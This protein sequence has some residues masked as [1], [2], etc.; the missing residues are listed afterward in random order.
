LT[1]WPAP[2]RPY[3]NGVA[4]IVVRRQNTDDQ[5]F[6][7]TVT[8]GNGEG[9]VSI[10]SKFGVPMSIDKGGH[11]RPQ[12][13]RATPE[14]RAFLAQALADAVKVLH[15]EGVSAFLAFGCLLGAVRD[16]QLIGHDS[17]GDLVY[18]ARSSHPFDVIL[19]SMELER[20]FQDKGWLTRRMS[21]GDFKLTIPLPDGGYVGC[22]VFTAFFRGESFYVMPYVRA[23]ITRADLEPLSEITLEGV[24]IPAP[25]RPEVLLE[26]TY[27]PGW[28][29]PDPSFAYHP[30]RQTRRQLA[31]WM[32]GERRHRSY[33]DE[34]YAR[35][36]QDVSAG[37]SPFASWVGEREPE[38]GSLVDIGA[39]TGRDSLWFA[40]QGFDVLGLDYSSEG[41]AL[42]QRHAKR[43]NLPA[44]FERMNLY[45][46]RRVLTTSALL[47]RTQRTDIVYARFLVH[48]LEDAGR[49]HLWLVAR[50]L[51][52]GS[53]GR[54]YIETRT[55]ATNHVFGEHFRQFVQADVIA[56]ELGTYGFDIEH[57]EEGHG[58]AVHKDED[59]RVCRIVA[60]MR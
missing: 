27:G 12:F 32:R 45:D 41:V 56:D 55:E 31:G 35:R 20:S 34:F 38:V 46:V 22:D 2:L 8:L 16:G 6:A 5:L 23:A 18:V 37:P 49:K 17:D 47:A 7:G 3:L 44:R 58:L 11:L 39:G 59:P 10:V 26:A 50:N 15:D 13:G 54:F 19:E 52:R 53:K 43:M 29:V 24:T 30:D 36:A 57:L 42:A 9:R 21:G 28:K 51:L 4:E 14:D 25:A 40:K 60:R 48:S 33:W 1:A